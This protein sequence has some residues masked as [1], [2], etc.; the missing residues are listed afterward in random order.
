MLT[1]GRFVIILLIFG[2]AAHIFLGGGLSFIS[3]YHIWRPIIESTRQEVILTHD[4]NSS[5]DQNFTEILSND[6]RR[7]SN[8]AS[9]DNP[10]NIPLKVYN[11]FT[12]GIIN[13]ELTNVYPRTD[14]SIGI[15]SIN[16]STETYTR[17]VTFSNADGNVH[18]TTVNTASG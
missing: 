4:I 11:P 2:V 3:D 14:K 17:N 16:R 7:S 10:V 13:G 8:T 1:A 9:V 5:S 15:G 18:S 6:E 12:N